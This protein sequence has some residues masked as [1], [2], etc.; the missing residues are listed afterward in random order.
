MTV[1]DFPN[2][3]HRRGVSRHRAAYRSR[4]GAC[5]GRNMHTYLFRSLN[6]ILESDDADLVQDVCLDLDK[7]EKKLKAIRRRL[8]GVQE[9]AADQVQRLATADTKLTAAIVAALLSTREG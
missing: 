1:I 9:Q 2:A 6:V 8:R 5:N 7:A 4:T 3:S